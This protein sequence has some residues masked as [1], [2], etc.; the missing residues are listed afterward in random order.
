MRARPAP[1]LDPHPTGQPTAAAEATRSARFSDP[2][3]RRG[4]ARPS[5]PFQGVRIEDP[6]NPDLLT[7]SLRRVPRDV[8]PPVRG[9]LADAARERVCEPHH[10]KPCRPTDET[11]AYWQYLERLNRRHASVDRIRPETPA[12][13]VDLSAEAMRASASSGFIAARL[14]DDRGGYHLPRLGDVPKTIAASANNDAQAAN[15][16]AASERRQAERPVQRPGTRIDAV[17]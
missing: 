7:Q 3:S 15:Q 16:Q 6:T 12:D 13:V 17:V 10:D 8:P 9:P 1:P 4:L 14:G 5:H 2:A 11:L